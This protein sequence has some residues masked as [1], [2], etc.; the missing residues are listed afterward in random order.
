MSLPNSGTL[1]GEGALVIDT[2]GQVRFG[3]KFPNNPFSGGVTLNNGRIVLD[4]GGTGDKGPAGGLGTGILTINGG[5]IDGAGN[6]AG[7]SLTISGQVWNAD[8]TFVNNR[9][10]EM[11]TGGITLGT[12]PGTTR[13][14]TVNANSVWL[15]LGGSISNG[16]TA[17][18]FTKA[19]AGKLVSTAVN[20]YS[21][22]TNISAGTLALGTTTKATG[23]LASSVINI[24]TGATFDVSNITGGYGITSGQTVT[25][26]GTVAGAVNLSGTLAPGNSPGTINTGTL[27]MDASSVLL[28]DLNTLNHATG[29]GVNDLTV[30]T[31]DLTLDGT[32]NLA[33]LTPLTLGSY[34]LMTYSGALTNNGLNIGSNFA[35]GFNYS[36][37][38]DTPNQVQ[39][40][41]A[42]P[43][44][45]T[46]GIGLMMGA[47]A[48]L[49]R[50]RVA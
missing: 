32:L 6:I 44:P 1:N 25:G 18:S 10:V 39:L 42:V 35:P 33:S 8:W 21:G 40:I 2:Q 5:E 14:V 34:T 27:N 46:V 38:L 47:M 30:V 22:A 4:G 45:A 43:E 11:G 17:D 36:I 20:T 19:G 16:T 29:G 15:E 48:M 9:K 24:A 49:R 12:A 7:H 41:V 23:S 13:T 50:R 28:Y 37:S 3:G 31:G 26:T